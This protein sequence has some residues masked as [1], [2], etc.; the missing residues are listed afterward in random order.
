MGGIAQNAHA[1]AKPQ[2]PKTNNHV[3]GF[4]FNNSIFK[5][6][7]QVNEYSSCNHPNIYAFIYLIKKLETNI[8]I[9][10]IKRIN[11][12]PGKIYRRQIDIKRHD[13]LSLLKTLLFYNSISLYN[14]LSY[15]SKLFRYDK[16]IE[17]VNANFNFYSFLDF[18]EEI[19]LFYLKGKSFD[20]IKNY[21][22]L[23]RNQFINFFNSL[24]QKDLTEY[25]NQPVDNEY[26]RL[27]TF[28]SKNYVGLETTKD[29]NCLFHAISLNL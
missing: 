18:D 5:T 26:R 1:V 21:I 29:G 20:Y 27:V 16:A 4:N 23:K 13:S 17:I 24:R 10:Y 8:S 7:I 12:A 22:Y 2:G 15:C 14:F 11:G 28:Y 25:N 3:E 6:S 19:N 9:R